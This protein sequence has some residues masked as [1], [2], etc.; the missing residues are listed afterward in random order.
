MLPI[1]LGTFPFSNVFA[2]VDETQAHEIVRD[3][4]DAGGTY[5][6]TSPY[7]EGVDSLMSRI[8]TKLPRESFY[9]STLCVKDRNSQISGKREALFAQCDDSLRT[10][11]LDH[12]DLYMTSTPEEADVPF[13]ETI[14]AMEELRDQGKI[15]EVGVCNV[16]LPQLLEYNS[17]GAVRY[18]QNRF[19]LID[20]EQDRDVRAYCVDKNIRLVPYN[21]IEWGLLTSKILEPF[22][23][24]DGD[25][26][27][28]VLPVFEPDRVETLRTWVKGRLLPLAEDVG[29][30]IEALAIYWAFSQPGVRVCPVGATARQQ[31]KTSLRALE[32]RGR[33]GLLSELDSAYSALESCIRDE[34]ELSV[35][36]YLK[37]SFGKW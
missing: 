9:L 2:E 34:F 23:L 11:G 26:R 1:G 30:G 15:R 13:A 10:L 4:L 28:A 31:L 16:T 14:S 37:N 27:A 25:V 36:D 12:I 5:I 24:R 20:Q 8:L 3:Y 22:V 19:S 7:Y 6:Q 32:L 33:S 21:V 17:S 18:V 35:N 29:V